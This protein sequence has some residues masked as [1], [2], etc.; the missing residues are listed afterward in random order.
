MTAW[1]ERSCKKVQSIKHMKL[2][3]SWILYDI[4]QEKS[5][6]MAIIFFFFLNKGEGLSLPPGAT[7]SN[8]NCVE[9]FDEGAVFR[10]FTGRDIF[11]GA[12]QYIES[13]NKVTEHCP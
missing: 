5:A 1:V 10:W 2:L 11:V 12:Y 13:V 4:P 9:T 8:K 6:N 7:E 3:T